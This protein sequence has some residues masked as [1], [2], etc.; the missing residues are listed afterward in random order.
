M[1]EPHPQEEEVWAVL[2]HHSAT[3][4]KKR[5][6]CRPLGQL[7]L[8][9]AHLMTYIKLIQFRR[10]WWREVGLLGLECLPDLCH[11]P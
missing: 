9:Y 4:K 6:F 11:S 7:V 3:R 1:E 5:G 2:L 8:S 10:R